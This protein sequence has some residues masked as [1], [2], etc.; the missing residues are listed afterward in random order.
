MLGI[1]CVALVPYACTTSN[2]DDGT[3]KLDY[4]G[5]RNAAVISLENENQ[6]FNDFM[7]GLSSA[8]SASDNADTENSTN[9]SNTVSSKIQRFKASVRN[10][11]PPIDPIE[12]A[13]S[14]GGSETV[15]IDYD[16]PTINMTIVDVDYC[17]EGEISNG[18]LTIHATVAENPNSLDMEMEMNA[19]FS[20]MSFQSVGE[21]DR[22]TLNGTMIGTFQETDTESNISFIMNTTIIE[23]ATNITYLL[24][25]FEFTSKENTSTLADTTAEETY[26]GRMYHS[27]LGYVDITTEE[28]FIINY[29]D[30]ST[31]SNYPQSGVM[32]MTG[33]GGSTMRLTAL[34]TDEYQ[35]DVDATGDGNIDR[36]ETG[37]WTDLDD[38]FIFFK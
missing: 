32:L 16:P 36:T 7:G 19:T 27:T 6:V 14:C 29:N 22:I 12:T 4:N 35:L 26:A 10:Q 31:E 1:C 33:D 34:S 30:T 24:E 15:T 3:V 23:E 5:N 28:V 13:G 11:H 37:N 38:D 17:E 20:D 9:A 2:D 21:A 8:G 18:T 25:D